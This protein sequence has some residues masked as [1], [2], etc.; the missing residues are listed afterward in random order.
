[1]HFHFRDKT[2]FGGMNR[3]TSTSYGMSSSVVRDNPAIHSK[4]C[5]SSVRPLT[6]FLALLPIV[7]TLATQQSLP[8]ED[9]PTYAEGN[10][11]STTTGIWDAG[12]NSGA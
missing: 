9:H 11:Y 5:P 1:M 8:F 7:S 6:T 12:G 10:L 4:H 2:S 3:V